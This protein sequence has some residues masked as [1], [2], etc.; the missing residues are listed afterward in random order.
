MRTTGSVSLTTYTEFP[1]HIFNSHPLGTCKISTSDGRNN[2]DGVVDLDTRVY[3]TDNVFVV[4]ASIFPGMVTANPSAYIVTVAEHAADKILALADTVEGKL[5]DQCAGLTWKGSFQCAEGL[6]CKATDEYY[7]QVSF[8]IRTFY[9]W[10]LER[11]LTCAVRCG[12]IDVGELVVSG[13]R[14]TKH[15]GFPFES[16]YIYI[17]L[18]S[19]Y[20]KH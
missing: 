13:I 11:V 12:V 19:T 5:H 8:A 15:W 9:L 10:L 3:G 14:S 17:L 2:G 1:S 4:D 18:G 6:T 20:I 7:A 16:T